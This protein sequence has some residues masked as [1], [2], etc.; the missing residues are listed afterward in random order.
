MGAKIICRYIFGGHFCQS[1][2]KFCPYNKFQP[3]GKLLITFNEQKY[4]KE[5]SI[6]NIYEVNIKRSDHVLPVYDAL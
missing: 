3:N 2:P 6:D 5:V 4:G 1:A